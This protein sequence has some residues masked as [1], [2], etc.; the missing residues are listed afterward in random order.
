VSR[1]PDAQD[2]L[3]I[4]LCDQALDVAVDAHSGCGL[5]TTAAVRGRP[6]AFLAIDGSGSATLLPERQVLTPQNLS[7]SATDDVVE[8]FR[9]A[10]LRD[11]S[12]EPESGS[13][14]P[15]PAHAASR[16]LAG[17]PVEVGQASLWDPNPEQTRGAGLPSDLSVAED[18][19]DLR[20]RPV[21]RFPDSP[22]GEETSPAGEGTASSGVP[23][24]LLLGEVLIENAEGKAESTRIGRLAETAAFVLLHPGSR[25]S[26]LQGALWPGRRS[27]PQTCRQMISR[28]RTWLGRTPAGEPY[29]MAFASTEGRLRMRPEVSSDWD[30]FQRLAAIGLADAQDTAHLA[31]ALALVRGRPFGAVAARELPWADLH[32]N[33]MIGAITDVA[34]ALATRLERAG[35]RSAAHDAALRGLLTECESEVLEAIV[36]RTAP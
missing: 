26:E 35:D 1:G 30:E 16:P 24:I 15:V 33:E 13:W 36:V 22:V 8:A 23:R 29:L 10:D 9:G 21:D 4:V 28:T 19:I 3:Q 12:D 34:H 2:P 14:N 17:H 27:N 6:G 20:E 11:P 25:P 18:V 7:R 5:I 32:I 31:D